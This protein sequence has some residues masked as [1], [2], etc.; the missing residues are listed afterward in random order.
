VEPDRRTTRGSRR[1]APPASRTAGRRATAHTPRRGPEAIGNILSELMARRGFAAVQ[2][3]AAYA[4]AWREAA[5]PLVAKHSRV[6]ALRRGSLEVVVAHS[7]L[8]QDLGFRKAQ[9]LETLARL[10]PEQGIKNLRFRLGA[11]E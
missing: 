6:G 9:L 4:T 5:G 7:A 2:N 8:L 11:I 10:L 1:T 3:A